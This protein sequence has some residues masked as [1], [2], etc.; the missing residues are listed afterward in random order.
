MTRMAPGPSNPVVH[1]ELHTSDLQRARAFYSDLCRWRPE[2]IDAG[3]CSYV[4]LDLGPVG[5]GAVECGTPR[6]LWLPYVEVPE[7]ATATERA[8]RLGGS[9][10]LEPR[11]GPGGWRSVVSVPDGAEIALW[12]SKGT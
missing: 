2:E 11:E 3:E 4:A 10:L 5:G 9:I 7:I 6:P 12:Q 1:L 8:R